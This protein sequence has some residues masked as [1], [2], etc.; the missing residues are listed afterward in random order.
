MV[1]YLSVLYSMCRRI[2][3]VALKGKICSLD[4]ENPML[5]FWDE[6]ALLY[7]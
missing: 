7:L 5:G 6:E 1:E 4:H 3:V 2:H